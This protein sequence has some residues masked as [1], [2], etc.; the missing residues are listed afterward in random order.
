MTPERMHA[1]EIDE[2]LS[3]SPREARTILPDWL[4]T[5]VAG[6]GMSQEAARSAVASISASTGDDE[7][8]ATMEAFRGAGSAYI[9]RE[10][11]QPHPK[12]FL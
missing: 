3:L 9:Q 8:T 7:V 1:L 5:F 4:A 6:G 2:F 10:K 12:G 11:P